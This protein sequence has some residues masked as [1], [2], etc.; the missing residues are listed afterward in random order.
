MG[1][2]NFLNHSSLIYRSDQK[3]EVLSLPDR[4]IDYSLHLRFSYQGKLGYLNR[5]LVAYRAG[6]ENSMMAVQ[7]EAVETLYWQAMAESA[8][9]CVSKRVRRRAIAF[10]VAQFAVSA[11]R[12]GRTPRWLGPAR[13]S[14]ALEGLSR[15]ST[16]A[17]AIV[18]FGSLAAKVLQSRIERLVKHEGLRIFYFR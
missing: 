2:G 18:A 5:D 17:S 4:F 12:S 7:T 3:G 6:T 15:Y 16:F 14:G 8:S 10:G 1:G 13:K 11:L 9:H